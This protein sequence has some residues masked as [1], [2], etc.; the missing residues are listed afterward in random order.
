MDMWHESV[1][2]RGIWNL[3]FEVG[4]GGQ[5]RCGFV[6]GSNIA[7]EDPKLFRKYVLNL[8]LFEFSLCI[9]YNFLLSHVAAVF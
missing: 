3:F 1:N 5:R 8:P 6:E 9:S 2:F 7:P 4:G